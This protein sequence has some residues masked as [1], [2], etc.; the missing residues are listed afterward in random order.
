MEYLQKLIL[1]WQKISLVQ[2]V[3]LA[4]VTLAALLIGALLIH[5]A[6]RPDMRMLY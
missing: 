5:W 1:I 3:L 4:A 6:Q 2:R